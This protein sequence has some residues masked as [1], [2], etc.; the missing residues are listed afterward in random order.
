MTDPAPP[1]P[2]PGPPTDLRP[3]AFV[4][5]A[6]AVLGVGIGL[7]CGLAPWRVVG[8]GLVGLA[9]GGLWAAWWMGG[10]GGED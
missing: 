10:G 9:V 6:A 8:C 3:L 2:A 4:A 1:A 5:G 7:A